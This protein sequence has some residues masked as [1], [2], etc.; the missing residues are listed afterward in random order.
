M[1]ELIK[2]GGKF[3]HSI[4]ECI[5]A[6]WNCICA[7][8]RAFWSALKILWYGYKTYVEFICAIFDG[9]LALV[10]AGAALILHIFIPSTTGK[11]EKLS[12]GA[13]KIAE[14][15]NELIRDENNLV[16]I[17]ELE[18]LNDGGAYATIAVDRETGSIINNDEG[19]AITFTQDIGNKE[20]EL[21]RRNRGACVVGSFA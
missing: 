20:K 9:L 15:I 18:S 8:G 10:K 14:T 5:T 13:R 6:A 11:F 16:D 4:G 7:L 12:E 3:F 17:S 1:S 19:R 2:T 21:L